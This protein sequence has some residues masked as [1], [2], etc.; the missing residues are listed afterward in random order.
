MVNL[1]IPVVVRWYKDDVEQ[2]KQCCPRDFAIGS[3]MNAEKE[4]APPV[5]SCSVLRILQKEVLY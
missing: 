3:G 4:N 1:K 2:C 5:F